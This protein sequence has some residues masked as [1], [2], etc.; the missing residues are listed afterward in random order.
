MA[1]SSFFTVTG[2][3]KRYSKSSPRSPDATFTAMIARRY[4]RPLRGGDFSPAPPK[5][6][7]RA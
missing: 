6:R 4:V 3:E 1:D 5:A 2:V 7:A